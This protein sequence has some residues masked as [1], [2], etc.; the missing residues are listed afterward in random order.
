MTLAPAL[1]FAGGSSVAPGTNQIIPDGR[2][3]TSLQSNGNVTTITTSTVSGATGFNSFS[4]FKEGAG[5][6]VNLA[7][8]N[9]TSNLINVVRDGTV[10]INGILNSYKDGK[11]GGNVYFADPYGFVVGSSG[12]VNTG[13]LNV[14]TPS[15]EFTDSLIS[16]QGQINAAATSQLMGG[17][18]PLSPDGFIAIKGR[19]NAL[20]GA[21]LVGQNVLIGGGR[22]RFDA[23]Q[24]DHAGKFAA[25]V[26][27][28]GL[29]SASGIV[30]RNG[31]IQIV[32]GNTAR[33]N[34]RLSTSA[35]NRNAGN[36]SV[37]AR[38]ISVGSKAKLAAAST[39]GNAGS[40]TAKADNNL[41]V[42]AGASF[43]VSSANGNAGSIELSAKNVATIAT[44]AYNLTAPNG[45]AGSLLID[46]YN[47]VITGDPADSSSGSANDYSVT[48]SINSH[49]GAVT[50]QADNNITIDGTGSI[51]TFGGAVTLTAGNM[52]TIASGGTV[53]TR[54]ANGASGA[55]SFNAPT[56]LVNGIVQSDASLTGATAAGNI[57]L[58]ASNTTS[59]STTTITING[60][61]LAAG[62]S[63]AT[64]G[65]I[66][67]ASTSYQK[68]NSGKASSD[69]EILINGTLTGGIISATSNSTAISSFTI[70]TSAFEPIF[71]ADAANPTGLEAG[72][73]AA[74]ATGKV[75]AGASANVTASG[76]VTLSS[77]VTSTAN[78]PAVDITLGSPVGAAVV[79][80]QITGTSTTEVMSGAQFSVGGTL[81]V[82]ATNN[83]TLKPQT[84][85][86]AGLI[87]TQNQAAV[88]SISYGSADISS[89]AT[90]D[91]GAKIT[92]ATGGVSVVAHNDN[93]FA[94][95]AS[96]YGFG[97]T[98]A[99]LTVAIGDV[100][101]S[102]VARIGADLGTATNP[103]GAV[104]VEASNTTTENLTQASTTIG[105]SKLALTLAAISLATDFYKTAPVTVTGASALAFSQAGQAPT[106]PTS[107]AK[108]SGSTAVME[109][110]ITSTAS[111]DADS[112]QAAPKV[113]S[114]G[115]VSIVADMY[116]TGLSAFAISGVNSQAKDPTS[117]DPQ[118]T[119]GLSVALAI[120][121]YTHSAT[122]YIGD[123]ATV[124]GTNIGVGART[125]IPLGVWLTDWSSAAAVFDELLQTV[126]T[127]PLIGSGANSSSQSKDFAFSGAADFITY[128]NSTVAWVGSGATLIQTGAAAPT[129]WTT[130]L[131]NGSQI[132]WTGAI[133]IQAQS[134]VE[135]L[136]I[137]GL[138]G[139]SGGVGGQSAD[140]DA[141]GG[142]LNV[143]SL[144]STT[145]AGVANGASLTAA[146]TSTASNPSVGVT[147]T[148]QDLTINL[149]PLNG[150]GTGIAGT[151][152][153]TSVS[154]D[155]TTHASVSNLANITAPA[156][157]IDA[158]QQIQSYS[159]SG[160]FA[161]SSEAGV[162]LSLAIAQVVTDTQAYVGDNHADI[163]STIDPGASS[164][165]F[166]G[167]IK[168]GALAVTAVTYG[169]DVVGSI[170]AEQISDDP[171]SVPAS[172]PPKAAKLL[173]GTPTQ[174]TTQ[175]GVAG[176][177]SVID[178]ELTTHAS[179]TGAKITQMDSGG[180][181]TVALNAENNVLLVSVSGAAAVLSATTTGNQKTF[182]A[183][184]V[185]AIAVGLSDNDTE[186]TI[187]SSTLTN[188]NAVDVHAIAGGL[189][190]IIGL[191]VAAN[192]N[193]DAQ[194]SASVA[195]SVSVG[196]IT[197]AVRATIAGSSIGSATASTNALTVSAYQSTDIGIGG[198]SVFPA[199]KAS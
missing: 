104:S 96:A 102:S 86:I 189:E 112:G 194:K 156:V 7:L 5:N 118:A 174:N 82:S 117:T 154:I 111:I 30:V 83:A 190:A 142:A 97:P 2:T 149:A 185:G 168:T 79:V 63:T 9:G 161:S 61:L 13:T 128:S 29:Q 193:A 148:A 196:E 68:L 92:Q 57:M 47:L 153:Y 69:A 195:G 64:A 130:T 33:I 187:A 109:S 45:I 105:T 110:N 15:K 170:A 93:D 151:G 124:Q 39:N 28:R 147:A 173:G 72:W 169:T 116:D 36:I 1:A 145:I 20:E 162:G 179:L 157:A 198:G 49:G 52:I 132:A 134:H 141:V 188:T 180:G 126:S 129:S 131:S 87:G 74:S 114:S 16:P 136:N 177:T 199:L 81:G 12:V 56:I 197:D 58:T 62:S 27:S 166:Q 66:T 42:K 100:S 119:T 53:D 158:S 70:T 10:V 139:I 8:P 31:S 95:K 34:G 67:L 101:A 3:A 183:A 135:S 115:A 37:A 146:A 163:S 108:V 90:I 24:L 48:T 137:G 165:G 54:V 99:G 77:Q 123:G 178:H 175:I 60:S 191:G 65:N 144:S 59:G 51:T 184:I 127:N 172:T 71:A 120:G 94:I 133:A 40:I 76:S 11:I 176:S 138:L 167:T 22:N 32:A 122:A 38:N 159:I 50:L 89:S 25:S 46:P 186:A 55:I 85:T 44:A 160:S 19:V 6:T 91:S 14:S 106:G 192:N 140:S 182:S 4:Q 23:A 171:N 41:N 21:R 143:A 164:S 18:V 152:L 98:Q 17:N 150:T 35:R 107:E 181:V 73:V 78:D 75:T 155:N 113:Y 88:A 84:L 125:N 103:I 43:D 121:N 26:N 80:G